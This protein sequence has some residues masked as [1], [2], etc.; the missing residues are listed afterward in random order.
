[1]VLT[2]ILAS[3]VA[4][5]VPFMWIKGNNPM[6]S[7]ISSSFSLLTIL[8][9][10]IFI[11]KHTINDVSPDKFKK[12]IVTG[13]LYGI[14]LICYIEAVKYGKHELLKFQTIFIFVISFIIAYLMFGEKMNTVKVLGLLAMLGGMYA[15]ITSN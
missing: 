5:S 7:C 9:Y 1:M 8:I 2:L 15:L 3:A 13:I 12:M 10:A 11:K 4:Y 14:G 6:T